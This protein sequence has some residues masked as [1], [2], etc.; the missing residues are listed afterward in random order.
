MSKN[1]IEFDL[2]TQ[3]ELDNLSQEEIVNMNPHKRKS[4]YDCAFLKENL[5]LWC[6]NEEAKKA[7][8]TSI[9]GVCMCRYWKPDWKQIKDEYKKP[10]YGYIK[11]TKKDMSKRDLNRFLATFFVPVLVVLFVIVLV[12][13]GLFI[14]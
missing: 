8:G 9:P 7:R 3:S 2:L 6:G 4:C 12:A 14:G 11:K 1:I 13:W 10:E 5:S